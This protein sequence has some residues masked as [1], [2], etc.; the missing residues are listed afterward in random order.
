MSELS[1][2]QLALSAPIQRALS[3]KGGVP[4]F[5]AIQAQAIPCSAERRDLLA[6][7]QTGTGKT[8][9]FALPLLHRIAEHPRKP[10]RRGVRHLVLTPTRELA[11]QVAGQFQIVRQTCRL[12]GRHDL[13]GVS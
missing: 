13:R 8:A 1:F 5:S 7:A 4:R 6:C 2:A 3:E 10:Y 11:G 9:A 12:S